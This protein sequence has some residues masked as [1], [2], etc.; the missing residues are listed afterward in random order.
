MATTLQRHRT[1]DVA[2]RE[3]LLRSIQ[4]MM[5]ETVAAYII[6]AMYACVRAGFVKP[7]EEV[8]CHPEDSRGGI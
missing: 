6:P 2:E 5:R 8:I 3:R 7:S 4:G 1:K